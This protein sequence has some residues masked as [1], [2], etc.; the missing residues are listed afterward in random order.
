LFQEDLLIREI[1]PF[2]QENFDQE[3]VSFLPAAEKLA[4]PS[5]EGVPVDRM[6]V[7][8]FDVKKIR[9]FFSGIFLEEKI[10]IVS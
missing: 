10:K 8:L 6:M 2:Q 9:V 7:L 5:F 3:S 4:D 1:H